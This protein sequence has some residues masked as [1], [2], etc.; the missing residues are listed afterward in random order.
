MAHLYLY[1]FPSSFSDA[2]I[3]PHRDIVRLGIRRDISAVV[4]HLR[5]G[6]ELPALVGIIY[7]TQMLATSAIITRVDYFRRKIALITS[8]EYLA[9]V[10]RVKL[11]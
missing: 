3:S 11:L 5:P 8:R 1:K 10:R 7:I 2:N 9:L 4:V 6:V